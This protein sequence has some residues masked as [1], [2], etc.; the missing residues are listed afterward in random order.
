MQNSLK[1]W[2][3][4][5]YIAAIYN[6]SAAIPSLANY[7]MNLEIYFARSTVPDEF[8]AFFYH[9][10]FWFSVLIFG[11]G[12]LLVARKPSENHGIIILAI[13][14]KIGVG[15]GFIFAYWIGKATIM[16]AIGGFGDLFFAA[17]F[18]YFLFWYYKSK[19][20]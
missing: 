18:L 12:Y 16:L 13:I 14:G 6:L 5:F 15:I 8:L 4:I 20:K 3:I 17:M 9:I 7:S 11:I 1:N 2:S 10:G 19:K